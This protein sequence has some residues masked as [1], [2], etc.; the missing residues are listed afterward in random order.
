M[1]VKLDPRIITGTLSVETPLFVIMY[2]LKYCKKIQFKETYYQLDSYYQDVINLINEFEWYEMENE[3][4]EE[5]EEIDLT[6]L[7]KFI[8]PN[9]FGTE[10]YVE[11]IISGYYHLLSF[12]TEI[13]LPPLTKSSLSFGQKTNFTPNKLNELIVFRI[14]K[15][16]NYIFTRS[17]KF[18]ECTSFIE[19]YYSGKLKTYKNSLLHHIENMDSVTLLKIYYNIGNIKENESDFNIPKYSNSNIFDFDSLKMNL[20]LSEITDRRKLISKM[21]PKTHYEAIIISAIRDDIDIST[22]SLPLKEFENLKRRNYI[23]YCPN[24]SRRYYLNRDFYRVSKTWSNNLSNSLIYT[25]DQIKDF[26]INEGFQSI[27]GMVF[28]EYQSYMRSTKTTT[29]FYFGYHPECNKNTTIMLTPLVDLHYD[30]IICFGIEDNKIRENIN[31]SIKSNQDRNINKITD[32]H[33]LY[34]ISIEEL[35][36]FFKNTKIFINPVNREPLEMRVINKLKIYCLKLIELKSPAIFQ[37]TSLIKTIEDLE[38]IRKLL[39][40][41]LLQL[42]NKIDTTDDPEIKENVGLF[43]NKVM[44]MGLYMRGWK[45]NGSD[46]YPLKSEDTIIKEFNSIPRNL[47]PRKEVYIDDKGNEILYT[48][49][50]F[51]VDRTVLSLEEAKSVLLELPIDISNDIKLL[52]TLRFEKNSCKSEE[53]MGM[54]F[55]GVHV[56]HSET[57][58]NCMNNIFKGVENDESCV[59][60]NSSWILFSSIWYL[61]ILGYSTPFSIDKIDNIT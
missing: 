47:I 22:S 44:E 36:D 61:M 28:S 50:Q 35:N 17:T 30:S 49:K 27:K 18:E 9:S 25:D 23:P 2:I 45:V 12:S 15:S 29:N 38:K 10:W 6:K 54:I 43:F 3:P 19:K 56:Y 21:I 59:R 8:S 1:R 32:P 20:T 58:I 52:H 39:D 33:S 46:N 57:L 42:K 14:I 60:T 16:L 31:L 26:V 13:D 48:A 55:K 40:S 51:I 41:K 53:I 24:F 37:C 11:N 5:S 7:I 4:S 34:Y